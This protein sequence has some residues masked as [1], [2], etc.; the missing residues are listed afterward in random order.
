ML[1]LD[2][3]FEES[4]PAE[5]QACLVER[6]VAWAEVGHICQVIWK[7]ANG[8]LLM[9]ISRQSCRLPIV[10]H[11]TIKTSMGLFREMIM[12]MHF[13]ENIY[14]FHSYASLYYHAE[15]AISKGHYS[16]HIQ[17]ALLEGRT[18]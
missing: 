14:G 9:E 12:V 16:R 2:K 11:L 4:C 15:S 17:A 7:P 10:H 1:V 8:P 3:R 6:L 18:F 5:I 13:D